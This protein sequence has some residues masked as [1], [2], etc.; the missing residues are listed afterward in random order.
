MMGKNIAFVFTKNP[1]YRVGV[2]D[3][4]EVDVAAGIR[5]NTAELVEKGKVGDTLTLNVVR[6]HNDYTFEE[7]DVKATLVEDK[8]DTNLMEEETTTS[9]FDDYFGDRFSDG[10]EGSGSG[11]YDD[12]FNDFFGDFF[13]N[14]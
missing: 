2:Y 12:F 11:P 13:G 1:A 10:S 9:Y 7:F 4:K 14:P 5:Q 6:I 3:M 8:G